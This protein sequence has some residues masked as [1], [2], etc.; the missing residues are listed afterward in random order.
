MSAAGVRLA[1]PLPQRLVIDPGAGD[2]QE[3][4]RG[5]QVRVSGDDLAGLPGGHQA[6]HQAEDDAHRLGRVDDLA[7]RRVGQV[8][9][10]VGQVLVN[11]RDPVVVSGQQR[12]HVGDDERVVVDVGDPR[13]RDDVPGR[14]AGRWPRGQAGAE[15]EELAGALLRSL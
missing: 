13:V 11:G 7:E 10:G 15:V 14:I 12:P 5:G 1:Q 6:E 8:R 9:G 3:A 2:R 4:A